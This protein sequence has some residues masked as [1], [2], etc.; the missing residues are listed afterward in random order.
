MQRLAGL[1][2]LLAA[3]IA[4]GSEADRPEGRLPGGVVPSRYDLSLTI[5]PER[6]EFTGSVS[7]DVDVREPV[8]VIWMHGDGLSIERASVRLADG[9]R[10]DATWQQVNPAGLAKLSLP[11]EI[12]PQAAELSFGWSAPYS[13][14]LDG[15]YRVTEAGRAY[16]FTQFEPIAARK[17]FPA[18]DEPAFKTP[19]EIALTVPSGETAITA[20]P[21]KARELLDNG[22]VRV[23]FEPTEPLPTYLIAFAVG[24]LD[25]VEADPVPANEARERPL[26]LRGV[27]VD[28]KG[29]RLGYALARTGELL[30]ALERYTGI[31]YPYA[32]LDIIAV[33]DFQ[34]GAMEN[35]GAVTFREYLLLLDES[36]SNRQKR[37][38][39]S[40]MAHELAHFW[41][42]NYVTHPWW[43]DIWLNEAFA[44]WFAAKGVQAVYPE[45]RPQARLF[46]R[47]LAVMEADSLVSARRIRQPI[48]TSDDI[49]NAF[50]GITYRKGAA[51]LGMFE[52]FVGEA[53]FQ[54]GVRDYLRAH[55]HGTGDYR[56]F[57]AAV[58]EN[59][60]RD[61]APAFETFLEQSGVPFIEMSQTC[62]GGTA[63]MTLEQ[64][65]YLPL[66]SEGDPDRTWQVPVC[67]RYGGDSQQR[68][69][70]TLLD[71][72]EKEIALNFCPEWVVPNA[73]GAGYYRWHVGAGIDTP[74]PQRPAEDAQGVREQMAWVDSLQAS[75]RAGRAGIGSVLARLTPVLG[76]PDPLLAEAPVPLFRFAIDQMPGNDSERNKAR[77]RVA[78]PMVPVLIASNLL[79]AA[80]PTTGELRS[81]WLTL[82]TRDARMEVLMDAAVK[83]ARRW[84]E[85]ERDVIDADVLGAVLEAAAIEAD[86]ARYDA[87]SETLGEELTAGQ[88]V[89]VVNA[90]G[91][92]IRPSAV[93][94]LRELVFSDRLRSNEVEDLLSGQAAL[95]ETRPA[96]WDWVREHFPRLVEIM[97]AGHAGELPG[98]AKGFC[99]DERAAEVRVFFRP[100]IDELRGGPR[101]LAQALEA[102]RICAAVTENQRDSYRNWLTVGHDETSGSLIESE[103]PKGD[104]S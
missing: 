21:E 39:A 103:M 56:D 22:L 96:N 4:I 23:E 13:E 61:L 90:L 83:R 36:S 15:L 10:L 62:E 31:G 99:S 70:C 6:D 44:T 67:L 5:V 52:R 88:R 100:H 91:H 79:P 74:V 20:A 17:A 73:G 30:A 72:A 19:F 2:C 24:P 29:K 43:D 57:L 27:A 94:R 66:G 50:D 46:E 1:L 53:A 76:W 18:F 26:P 84:I 48:E 85:G 3:G 82:M 78:R 77:S 65:R 8:S 63:R 59:S 60:G 12:A 11:R 9:T 7:I 75:V 93:A 34:A 51:V 69:R 68:E 89:A 87:L 81:Q 71:T 42:G 54:R 32:K 33:P 98:L 86:G 80:R 37:A 64:S 38:F 35:V 101:N 14:E 45:H 28:G 49:Y 41:F 16:A 47:I 25:V 55:A 92:A 104:E 97:P 95:P 58:S 102:I 40:V